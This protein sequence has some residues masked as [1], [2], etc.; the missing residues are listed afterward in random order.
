[1]VTENYPNAAA[2]QGFRDLAAQLEG[3][4]NRITVA[5]KR[6]IEAVQDYNVTVRFPSNLTAMAVRLRRQGQL[7]G[8]RREGHGG[9]ATGR[10]RRLG[11]GGAPLT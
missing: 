7:H 2:N 8:R 4:E 10:F 3:T 11:A 9:A 1:V 5:R 6:Y